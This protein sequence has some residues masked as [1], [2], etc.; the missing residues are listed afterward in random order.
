M[1]CFNPI[2]V[3]QKNNRSIDAIYDEAKLKKEN[4]I[5]FHREL[6]DGMCFEIPCGH[7]LG[8]R[9]DHAAMWAGRIALETKEWKNNCFVTLTYNNGQRKDGTPNLPIA[10]NGKPTVN[11]R[12]LQLFM[13]R[14]RKLEKGKE[15]YYQTKIDKN[16][17]ISSK[18]TYPIKYFGC[19]EYGEKKLRPHAHFALFNYIPD[20]LIPTKQVTTGNI[21]Y[22]LYKSPKLQKIWSHGFV[23]IGK[24]NYETAS[25]IARYVQKKAGIP[26]KRRNYIIDKDG[27]RHIIKDK[28][29]LEEPLQEFL[30]MSQGIGLEYWKKNKE[31]MKR[32]GFYTIQT[33]KGPK[34]IPLPRYFKK[35]WEEENWEEYYEYKYRKL[36]ESQKNLIEKLSKL[37]FSTEIQ[38]IFEIKKHLYLKICE[39]ALEGKK[40]YFKRSN[41]QPIK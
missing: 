12:D 24:L 6:K 18:E 15:V 13:K 27:T 8:C 25:Y 22:M 5:H 21:T 4:K 7:C 2:T 11:K 14:L 32:N 33:E 38:N 31:K 41:F 17:N 9:L 37:N 1:T 26:P 10:P 30:L 23:I 20:D 29:E 28:K 35:K 16:G 39:R 3:Y 19:A 40:K 36:K 34:R